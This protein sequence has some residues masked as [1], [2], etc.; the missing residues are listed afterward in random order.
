MRGWMVA[1]LVLALS[2]TAA[3]RSADQRVLE[4]QLDNAPTL[5]IWLSTNGAIEIDGKPGDL[6]VLDAK[7]GELVKKKGVVHYGR[8]AAQL[9]PHPN[10]MKIMDLVIKHQLPIKMI[11]ERE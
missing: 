5:K 11:T 9:E 6:A 10:A 4:A 2:V 8:D 1:F 7:L 3:C